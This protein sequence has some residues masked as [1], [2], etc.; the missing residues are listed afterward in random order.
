METKD[1]SSETTTPIN[2]VT[3][4][5][6]TTTILP[7]TT[8]MSIKQICEASN[9]TC[10]QCLSRSSKCYFCR[11]TSKCG[12]Y[13]YRHI[14]PRYDECGS[15]GDI[16]WLTCIVNFEILIITMGVIGGILIIGITICCCCCC[17][18]RGRDKWAKQ[19]AKWQ[20]EREERKARTEERKKERQAKTDEIR[21]KYGLI[22]DNPYQRFDA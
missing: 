19:Q 10:D 20:K 4:I 5:T 14:V 2:N 13:P 8:T 6:E 16:A 3:K 9:V 22:N 7:E 17:R 21:R 12:V 11:K 15:M 18:K 1:N